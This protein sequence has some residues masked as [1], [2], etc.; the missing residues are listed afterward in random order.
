MWDVSFDPVD[1]AEAIAWFASR[2]LLTREDVDALGEQIAKRAFY[3]SGVAQLDVVTQVW[4]AI[5]TA[6]REGTTLEDFKAEIGDTL[7]DAWQGD[8]ANPPWRIET[9]FRTNTQSAYA[10][11]RYKEASDPDAMADRPYW[12]FD[13]ILDDRTTEVCE[14]CDGTILPADSPWWKSHLPP[15]HFN[16]RSHF[17]TL[18]EAQAKDR[19]VAKRPPRIAAD[20]GF[21]DA[22]GEDEWKPQRAAYPEQLWLAFKEK[23]E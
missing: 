20:E 9:I 12:M 1:A 14:K 11:G 8:V 5:D 4:E 16:C 19:G 6:I 2:L 13:A 22:P 23:H 3:V 17:L 7:R 15:L 18:T 10:A 21:G